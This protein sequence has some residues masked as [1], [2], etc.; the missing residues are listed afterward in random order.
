MKRNVFSNVITAIDIGTTKICVLIAKRH[1]HDMLE[2]IGIGKAA[3][4]GLR[5][6]VVV[7]IAKTVNSIKQAINEA[8][9][10]A[11][12]S[13]ET[14]SIGISGSHI[15]SFNSEGAVPIKRGEVTHND[16]ATVLAS[17]KAIAIPE[18]QQILHVLPQYFIIDDNERIH[19]PLGMYGIRLEAK[20]HIITGAVACVQNLIKCCELAGVQ[21]TDIVLEQIASASAVLSN[22]ERTLGV[23]VLDIGGGTSDLALYRNNGITYT[24]VF[25]VA[26]NQFTQDVAIGLQTTLQDA[27]RIKKEYGI[28]ST[29]W[30]ETFF[31]TESLSQLGQREVPIS[32]LYAIVQPRAEELLMLVKKTLEQQQLYSVIT[33]GFVLTGGGSMLAGFKDLAQEILGVSVRIGKPRLTSSILSTLDNPIY[34]TGYG[35]LLQALKKEDTTTDRL[36][37]PLVS[38]VVAR[39]KSWVS[40]FF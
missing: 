24:A 5:K 10:M 30:Q 18:G 8:Q 1:T 19:D 22:D 17:A 35:L 15:K 36:S 12:Y 27:E 29:N 23:G 26:G 31:K 2:I 33:A 32:E 40:D 37:G 14:A 9:V 20:V 39:M 7:D 4:H 28:V 34:A 6:G 25:P 13:I 11:G 16:I 21:V 38:R 3:S